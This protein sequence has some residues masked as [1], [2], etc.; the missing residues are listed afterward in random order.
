MLLPSKAA[1]EISNVVDGMKSGGS[2][3]KDIVIKN[4]RNKK[5][6]F[7]S[8]SPSTMVNLSTNIN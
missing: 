4:K 7:I 3:V 8:K 2:Y 5:Y 1:L 6:A